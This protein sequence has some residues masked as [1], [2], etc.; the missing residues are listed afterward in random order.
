VKI[1][2]N[3]VLINYAD[4]LNTNTVESNGNSASSALHSRMALI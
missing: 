2:V 1:Q 3:Y 4:V